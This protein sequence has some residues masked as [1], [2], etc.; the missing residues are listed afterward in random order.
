MESLLGTSL[1]VFVGLTVVITGGAAI[2][3]GRALAGNWRPVIQ[4]VFATFGLALFDRFLL[5]ALF[6]G[7]LLH[8][9]GFLLHFAVILALALIAYR[10]TQVRQMVSQYPWKYEQT[11][12]WSYQAK[13]KA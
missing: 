3:T 11:S 8:L 7:E 9:T 13:G 12:L 10:I 5:Y 2:L 4:V 6:E 1:G